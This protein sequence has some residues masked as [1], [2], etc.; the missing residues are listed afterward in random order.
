[1]QQPVKTHS[2]RFQEAS[3]CTRPRQPLPPFII[4]STSCNSASSLRSTAQDGGGLTHRG[5]GPGSGPGPP[6][7]RAARSGL[8]QR[9][10]RAGGA[11]GCAC[12]AAA[13]ERA[14]APLRSSLA[15][16]S[17]PL[18]QGDAAKDHLL[19]LLVDGGGHICSAVWCSTVHFSAA[20]WGVEECTGGGQGGVQP[21]AG[22]KDAVGGGRQ[23]G[24]D[25]A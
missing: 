4:H 6:P 24:D 8:R 18:T 17:T 7:P 19:V 3:G 12:S 13:A 15:H 2:Q 14:P 21:T 1:M 23:A 10:G 16:S 20:P 25:G 5:R 11:G 9:Q 22:N